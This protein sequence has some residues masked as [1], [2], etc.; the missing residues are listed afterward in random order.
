MLR[1]GAYGQQDGDA[2]QLHMKVQHNTSTIDRGRML[3]IIIVV[4]SPST[5]KDLKT[6]LWK[7]LAV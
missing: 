4:A 3:V 7:A 1:Q 6:S 2:N 5:S